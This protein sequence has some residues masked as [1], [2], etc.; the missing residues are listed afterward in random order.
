MDIKDKSIQP[1]QSLL[2]IRKDAACGTDLSRRLLA[3][4]DWFYSKLFRQLLNQV[5]KRRKQEV[6][7]DLLAQFKDHDSEA[8]YRAVNEDFKYNNMREY[9]DAK[10]EMNP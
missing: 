9:K 10:T 7:V 5:Y 3:S 1:Y 8:N 6:P 4:R 2:P